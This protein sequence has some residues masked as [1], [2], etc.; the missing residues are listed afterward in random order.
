MVDETVRAAKI[1]AIRD[2]VDRVREVLPSSAED[3]VSDRTR[4]EIVLLNLFVAIQ[5]SLALASHYLADAGRTVPGTYGEVFLALADAGML[6]RDLA[7]RLAG[8]AG[9]AT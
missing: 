4:R 3:L 6:P 2:A 5:E 1:A 9:F 7:Q 8:A